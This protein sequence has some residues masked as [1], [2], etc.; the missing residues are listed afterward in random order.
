M[1][2][3]V[4]IAAPAYRLLAKG[5]VTRYAAQGGANRS[6]IGYL[7]F[8]FAIFNI[9]GAMKK[10]TKKE[11]QSTRRPDAVA[12]AFREPQGSNGEPYLATLTDPAYIDVEQAANFLRMSNASVRRYLTQKRLRRFKAGSRTLLLFDDVKGLVREVK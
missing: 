5:L 4:S 1:L 7:A 6:C 10:A 2:F 3:F 8:G 11:T 12:E 9:G